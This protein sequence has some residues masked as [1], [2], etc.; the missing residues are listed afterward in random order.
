[1]FTSANAVGAE[2][3]GR[4]AL[5]QTLSRPFF[6]AMLEREV[7]RADETGKAFTLCV[8]DVDDLKRVNARSGFRAGDAVV[9]AVADSIRGRLRAPGWR[10]VPSAVARYDG[11]AVAAML[12]HAE[13]ER[14]HELA[15]GIA[16]DIARAEFRGSKGVK[17]SIAA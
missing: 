4:D 11:D 13:R 16:D 2:T 17:V 9:V 15:S 7:V 12:R 5:T 1:M 6:V 3:G 14:V 10:D 8:A